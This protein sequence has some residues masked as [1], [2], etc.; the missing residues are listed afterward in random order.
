MEEDKERKEPEMLAGAPSRNE[1]APAAIDSRSC[2]AISPDHLAKPPLS[3]LAVGGSAADLSALQGFFSGL[4]ADDTLCI[5]TALHPASSVDLLDAVRS[6][7]AMPVHMA[8]HGSPLRGNT[9]YTLPP[10][11]NLIL[12][13]GQLQEQPCTAQAVW[14]PLNYLFSSLANE[15][16]ERAIAVVLSGPEQDGAE[17][18]KAVRKAGGLVLVQD[19][20]TAL[21]PVM[22]QTAIDTGTADMILPVEAM[23]TRIIRVARRTSDLALHTGQAAE[24]D[25]LLRELFRIV[26]SRTGHDFSSY[27]TNTVLRRIERRMSVHGL[28]V[29]TDYL[30]LLR[31]NLEE[32]Q[33][34]CKEFL[35]GVTS[36][37]RDPEAF[38]VIR[39]VVV[40]RI[41]ADRNP[42]DPVRIWHPCCATG[43][44]VYSTAML[45]R[46]YQTEHHLDC[47]VLIFATDIDEAAISTARAGLYPE[48][49]ETS[50]SPERLRTFFRKTGNTYQVTKQLREMIVFAHHNVIRDPPFSR[51]DLLVCRNFLI[52][53]N[54]DMQ[55]RLLNLFHQVLKPGA[56]LFCGSS[57]TVDRHAEQ[58]SAVHKK[59]KIFSRNSDGT[60][61]PAVIPPAF[62]LRVQPMARP[63]RQSSA[64]EAD[65]ARCVSKLLLERYSPPCVVVNEKFDV[66]HV[67]TRTTLFLELPVGEPTRDILRMAPA[68]LRPAL[69]AAIHKAFTE[70]KQAAFRGIAL[71]D[72][73][74]PTKI[75][76][77]AEPINHPGQSEKLVMVIFEANADQEQPPPSPTVPRNCLPGDESAKDA[78]IRQLEEQL[79]VTHE[80]LL[81]TIE[82]LESS[83]EGLVSVNEELMSTNEE[84]QAT[85]EELQSTNEELET[86]RE[87]LQSLNEELVTVNTELHGKV[88]E[89]N[90]ANSDMEN[91]L[92]CSDMATIFLDRSFN[93]MRF[94]PAICVVFNIIPSDIGRPFRHLAGAIDWN[95]FTADAESVLLDA[96]PLERELT[97]LGSKQC[98]IMRMLPYR[99]SHGEI[100]GI[101]VTFIDISERKRAEDSLRLAKEHWERTFNS[102]PDLIAI[103]DNQHRVVQ[104]NRA[105]AEKL[106]K[107]PEECTG[108]PCY[109]A[110]H[111]TEEPPAFCPHTQTLT[112]GEEH[113]A[114]VHAE[115]LG[116][117]FFVTTTPLANPA[118]QMTG[119][120][121][122]ARNIT[123]RKL[124]EHALRRSEERLRRLTDHLPCYVAYVD[125]NE[126]YQ[127]A[128]ATYRS[129]FGR[130]PAAVAGSSVIEVVGTENYGLIKP[131]IDLVLSGRSVSF[132]YP[133][134]MVDGSRRYVNVTYVP[135]LLE[136]GTVNGFYV[137]A[138]DLSERRRAEEAL[139]E[140][141]ERFRGMFENHKAI[142]L[143]I[144]PESGAIIDANNAATEYYG[145][146]R[147][148]LR[149]LNISDINK[150]APEEIVT[151]RRSIIAGERNSFIAPH[152]RAD[153]ELRQVEVYSSPIVTEGQSLIFSIIHD[154][155]ERKRAEEALQQSET[156]YRNLVLHSPVSMFIN[157]QGRID[158]IN[159]A[160]QRL[161]GAGKP[162]EV[163]G[164][165]PFQLFHADFH[166]V[167]RQRIAKLRE[168]TAADMLVEKV[169]RL[170]G[171]ERDVEVTAVPFTDALGPAIL[172]MMNDIT[173]R[174]QTERER[175]TTVAFL[176]LVNDCRN[177]HDLIKAVAAYIKKTVD[178]DAVGIRLLSGA[179]YPYLEIN[180]ESGELVLVEQD[181]CA[182]GKFPG[183]S[184]L[185]G[186]I[187]QGRLPG[188]VPGFT[189]QGS[190]ITNSV[191]QFLATDS[192]DDSKSVSLS[193]CNWRRYESV[194]LLPLRCGDTQ[195]GLLQLN[196]RRQNHFNPVTL[197]FWERLAGH[198]SVALEKFRVEEE[199]KESEERWQF[200]VEGSNDGVWDR[201]VQTGIVY[202]S[203][204]WKYMLGYEDHEIGSSTTE[205]LK[206]VHAEDLPK[207]RMELGRHLT[208]ETPLY[209]T[210]YRMQC[211]DGSYKWILARGKVISRTPD[212]KPIRFVGTHC[213]I[214]ERK[215]LEEQLY[216]SQKMEAVG[217]LAGGIA[218]DFNNILTAIIG[219]SHLIAMNT[220]HVPQE[221]PIR[222]YVEQIQTSAERAAEL[223]QALLAFSRKQVM[224][225]KVVALND[226]ISNLDKMLRRL[227]SE[228]IDLLLT[229]CSEELYVLADKSKIEQVLI[230]LATNAKDAMAGNGTLSITTKRMTMDTELI[231]QQGFGKPGEYACISVSDTGCGI[232]EELQN[233]IFEPFF[234]TKE[235]GKGTGLGL[236]IVYGIVKQHGGYISVH[237][238]PLKGTTFSICL[239]LAEKQEDPP[240]PRPVTT[241]AGGSE[242]LLL[243]EDDPAVRS[244]HKTLF[245]NAGYTVIC[246]VD[247][248]DALDQF[249][250]YEQDI[251]LLVLDVV[252]PKLNGINLYDKI[253]DRRP[254]LKPL[255]LSGY[256]A[257]ILQEVGGGPRSEMILDKPVDPRTLLATV[258]ALLNG[259]ADAT[260]DS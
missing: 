145:F 27:K 17:G 137:T 87:E 56:F 122:V 115:E 136:D 201:N 177:R 184:C 10:D 124:A 191:S 246:A 215:N 49:I 199:L 179:L 53:L 174:I 97:S 3:V 61:R 233:K 196:D 37:F 45:I 202:F 103:L 236:S 123:E 161:F 183:S 12:A 25:S 80:Q 170:D 48:T 259:S 130:E 126:R 65:T 132:D 205:W 105:M 63:V 85:N 213:D 88:E 228:N 35:I 218:H 26:R 151:M 214:T 62:P 59:W 95:Q 38:E 234:T 203:R 149:V 238:R 125:K 84:F 147:H 30:S 111:C 74:G 241:T 158:W 19:P 175:E 144:E 155:T 54:T 142:M 47:K 180:E 5:L 91:F 100:D 64:E 14:R 109:A 223:T 1:E 257:D 33:Q 245:R 242:T 13:G 73:G 36:F 114:E 167:M 168:G 173:E 208:G 185:C 135:D 78:L 176:Q 43:E 86:S 41:F 101:V 90:R 128:N 169:I 211:K 81:T 239:P 200:A 4:P 221:S 190:F 60:Q 79:R 253:R 250:R 182:D 119:A 7:S 165:T 44:E 67:S 40:P 231:A 89:L 148:E 251:D 171:S 127:F 66:V 50:V 68:E 194:A 11:K 152:R 18:V 212:G 141:E 69:R 244:F 159:P 209:A 252:M 188:T 162:E 21:Q 52:Y 181:I 76:I 240:P 164:M 6:A 237:S 210:E 153:G 232:D 110:V 225:P 131:H 29:L 163:Y 51:L 156:R 106:G 77:V 113:G 249:N 94:T 9:V 217:Q 22:P 58:F 102:V 71:P 139:R 98:H 254:D 186:T 216:Q 143:L 247:G 195:F 116:G 187:I 117:D 258:R 197:A 207:V 243:A 34:L 133:M 32:A 99:T 204:Q 57:E 235:V 193:T 138:I 55:L 157:R 93:I 20:T 256:T 150:M 146:S 83:N 189:E 206:R 112:D 120:V 24:L 31:E 75:T 108:L 107:H 192:T 248:E 15:M 28:L 222:G 260:H 129:W 198:L 166:E 172:V 160:A 8:C 118:G 226:T 96:I 224:I 70:Q 134:L 154:V 16:T 23:G 82:Q 219:Y 46:E 2:S 255:F 230:N 42:E 140:S 39:D 220:G 121:H 72:S 104:V 178:C 227:I 92:I 229:T